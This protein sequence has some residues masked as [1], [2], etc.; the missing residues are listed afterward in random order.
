MKVMVLGASGMLGHMITTVLE[1]SG[2][3]V[4]SLSRSGKFGQFPVAVNL[5]NWDLVRTQLQHFCPDWVINAAGILNEEV[6]KNK[7]SAILINSYLPQQLV[8]AGVQLGYRTITVGSDC[9]FEGN[10]GHYTVEDNPD[11]LS[12]YGKTKQLG[13]VRNS[14]DLTIRTSIIGPEIDLEGRGLLLWLM[15]QETQAEGWTSAIWTGVTTLELAKVIDALVSCQI[16]ATGLWQLVPDAPITK[17]NLLHLMNATFRN[18]KLTIS[19]VPGLGH[20]RSLINDRAKLWPVP[21]YLEMLI[22]LKAW[23]DAHPDLYKATVFELSRNLDTDL[24][25]GQGPSSLGREVGTL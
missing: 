23:T 6:D 15:S 25:V 17:F 8:D 10:S 1:D 16:Q 22:E 9:V 4:I 18:S 13:E 3:K 24:K 11:A 20:D 2:H 12:W 19:E 21:N 7:A 5:E 14:R